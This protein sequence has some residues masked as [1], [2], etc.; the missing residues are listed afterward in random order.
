MLVVGAL[1]RFNEYILEEKRIMKKTLKA[2]L[3]LAL[4]V[5]LALTLVACGAKPEGKYYLKS[6]NVEGKELNFEEYLESI[7]GVDPGVNKDILKELFINFNSDGT[8]EMNMGD[9]AIKFTWKGNTMEAEG[10]KQDFKVKGN[11]VII[12]DEQGNE[13]VYEK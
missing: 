10:E 5:A 2:V 1:P 6:V 8:G 12:S 4:I 9:E 7:M 11:S 3:S 13:M